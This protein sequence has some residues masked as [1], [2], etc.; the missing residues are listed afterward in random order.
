VKGLISV[1]LPNFDKIE[2]WETKWAQYR[3]LQEWKNKFDKR[4]EEANRQAQESKMEEER[5]RAS[6]ASISIRKSQGTI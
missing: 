2:D 5:I 1:N 3:K 6:N 4:V